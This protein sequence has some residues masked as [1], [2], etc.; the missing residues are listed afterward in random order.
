MVRGPTERPLTDLL[1]VVKDLQ[2]K[3]VD[4]V[5][6]TRVGHLHVLG[7]SH[8][9]KRTAFSLGERSWTMPTPRESTVSR[10]VE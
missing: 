9:P 6:P 10:H 8:G 3:V 1:D 2:A 7:P 5:L 4:L